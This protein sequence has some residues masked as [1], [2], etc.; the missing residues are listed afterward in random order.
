MVDTGA[1]RRSEAVDAGH[2]TPPQL[3]LHIVDSSEGKEGTDGTARRA[4][5]ALRRVVFGTH[6]LA[7]ADQAVV[8]GT[9]LLSTVLVGRFT[10]PSQLGIYA[11][12]ISILGSV[13]AVQDALILLPYTIRRHHPTS[14][15][16]GHA[17]ISLLH[18]IW[19]AA[20]ATAVMVV[21]A[22][23]M[24]AFWAEAQLA[25]LVFTLVLTVP[26]AM[27]REFGRTYAF[28]RLDMG[29]AFVLDA[30]V[31]GLQLAVLGWLG[32]SG[33]M[34]AVGACAALGF[35]CAL[36]SLVWLYRARSCFSIRTVKVRQATA[37]SW[38][39]GKWLCAGQVTV[40]VQG[41][42]SY[43][44]LPLLIGMAETGVF[45]ACNS[46]ASLANPLL[47]AFRNMLTPR[48][49]LAFKEGGGSRLRRQAGHDAL[50]LVGAMTP[51][52]LAIF[53]GGDALL[54]VVYQGPEYSG[55]SHIV[56]V[57]ALAVMAS[58]AGSPASNAMASM[59]RPQ[60]IVLAT[61]V[62]A[63]VTVAAVWILSIEW[64]LLGTAYGMLAGSIAGAAAR[65]VA[66][67]KT[68]SS[69]L[70]RTQ[71]MQV[72]REFMR[73]AADG[74]CSIL[75]LDQGAQADVFV[76]E[77]GSLRSNARP[78]GP[79]VVKLYK[80]TVP[81]RDQLA[82]RQFECL[83]R[84][85]ALV[86]DRTF[87]GWRISAPVPLYMCRSPLGL[88]MT[89]VPGRKASW[90]FRSGE[91]TRKIIDTA[92]QAVAAAL[93]DYWA[94]G[95]SHGDLNVD[96]ILLDPAARKISFVDLDFSPLVSLGSNGPDCWHSAAADLAYL[97]YSAAIRA[98]RDVV[99]PDVHARKL[100]FVERVLWT[101]VGTI[102]GCENKMRLLNQIHACA[103]L[104]LEAIDVSWS[105]QGQWRRLLR[106]STAR[107]IDTTLERLKQEFIS[108]KLEQ[109]SVSPKLRSYS[110]DG[111]ARF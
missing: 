62:G 36:P 71:A 65:W 4:W 16:E 47:S 10:V 52:C 24:I 1:T 31:A 17:G 23:V 59:E 45:A 100:K 66:F 21:A 82:S 53:I 61:S 56:T 8:S 49:V 83:S 84:W 11:I 93:T 27:Q 50:L 57:L 88:V 13:L 103:R 89:I 14:S 6:F 19:L 79:V 18:S 29:N 111:S 64:G 48:A 22:A 7:L 35:G 37:E 92:P 67:Q 70:R 99:R 97:L 75:T 25:W 39:L 38:R 85:H 98:K 95:Q 60:A 9:S 78:Q 55:Q 91:L 74:E 33:R 80:S 101:F 110:A 68:V 109:E 87:K 106:R 15:P 94:A 5:I 58:A 63:V 102:A 46:M 44:V 42:V 51:F 54:H 40:S 28:A 30:S 26:F 34:S 90:H 69:S 77:P 96:N 3:E 20:A 104:H 12:G 86:G 73:G 41:Y 43:W 81:S 72:L 32:W 105:P 2:D 107:R 76:A 108:P